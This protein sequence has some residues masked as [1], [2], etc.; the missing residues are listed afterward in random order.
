MPCEKIKIMK[1]EIL[2]SHPTNSHKNALKQYKAG[3]NNG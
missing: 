2:A 3:Q 1:I